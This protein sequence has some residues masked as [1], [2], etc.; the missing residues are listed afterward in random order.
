ML[1]GKVF[2]P[3]TSKMFSM[4]GCAWAACRASWASRVR[5]VSRSIPGLL[6]GAGPM[7]DSVPATRQAMRVLSTLDGE[8]CVPNMRPLLPRGNLVTHALGVPGEN[9]G[10]CLGSP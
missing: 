8:V 7:W 3:L 5:R 2:V 6:G 9:T 10:H 4:R 1:R